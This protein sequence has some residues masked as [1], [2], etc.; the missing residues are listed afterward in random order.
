M[1][2]LSL[3]NLTLGSDE[4]LQREQLKTVFGNGTWTCYCGH[5][6]GQWE[7]YKFTVQA[8]STEDALNQASSGCGGYGVTCSGN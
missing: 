6:G 1:K 2:K 5:T 3:K 7:S 8:D 4:L